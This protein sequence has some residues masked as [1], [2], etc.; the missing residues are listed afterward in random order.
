MGLDVMFYKKKTDET[1]EEL[2]YYDKDDNLVVKMSNDN[3]IGHLGRLGW[4][5]VHNIMATILDEPS[6]YFVEITENMYETFDL[7]WLNY[8]IEELTIIR[9][10]YD[11]CVNAI[12]LEG[13]RIFVEY[14]Y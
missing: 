5:I 1:R 14:S 8:D 2:C 10:I 7:D 9:D 6:E 13:C 3:L 12:E 11:K 4:S